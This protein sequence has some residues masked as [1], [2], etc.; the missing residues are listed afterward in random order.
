MN[1]PTTPTESTRPGR[2]S[3]GGDH[4]D[5]DGFEHTDT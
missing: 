5:P 2:R 4:R 3:T 1:E